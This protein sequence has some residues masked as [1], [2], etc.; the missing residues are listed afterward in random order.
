[1]K[2]SGHGSLVIPPGSYGETRELVEGHVRHWRLISQRHGLEQAIT[3]A[4]S[5]RMMLLDS[6]APAVIFDA[7]LRSLSPALDLLI[8]D[9]TCFAA[10]S[11]RIRRVIDQAA[12]CDV[13]V[14]MVRSH[15]KLDSLGA[16]YGRLGSV[17][18]VN[19][20]N[21]R[22]GRWALAN[23][24]AETRDALRLIGGAALP[25]HFPPY[26]G[27]PAYRK[28]TNQRMAAILRNTHRAGRY[29]KR[30]LAGLTAELRFA[31]GLYFTLGGR[32][33]LDEAAARRMAARMADD[34]AQAGLPIRH[35]GSFGFD[36]AATEWFR[37]SATG[38]Y[39]VRVA[40]PDL[41]APLWDGLAQAIAAWW[42]RHQEN[43]AA[44]S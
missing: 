36:F 10:G 43:I 3:G 23:L 5:P 17:V 13:P 6:S 34:L 40:V 41:P 1:V 42:L 30:A 38:Q 33:V 2:L 7:A 19:W 18:F 25:A 14:A 39:S 12:E 8:F 16:E 44:A 35:A 4:P 32:E 31:H 24:P 26:V 11:R 15:T 27:S 9:T 21:D 37:D 20:R 29:F 28:L 22:R